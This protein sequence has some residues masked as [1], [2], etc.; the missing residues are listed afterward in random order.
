MAYTKSSGMGQDRGDA[1]FERGDAFPQADQQRD[2]LG[3]GLGGVDDRAIGRPRELLPIAVDGTEKRT[4][5]YVRTTTLFVV[6]NV[7]TGSSP[8]ADPAATATPSW[9]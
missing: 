6:L 2:Q 8:S 1:G 7:G 4:R 9:R 5:D 3:D